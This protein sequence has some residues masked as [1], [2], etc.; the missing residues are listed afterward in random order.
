MFKDQ[1]A[2]LFEVAA[3]VCYKMGGIYTGLTTKA[4]Y[5]QEMWGDRYFLVGPYLPNQNYEGVFRPARDEDIP[6]NSVRQAVRMMR[7]MGASI[8]AG[9]WL[10]ESRPFVLLLDATIT[11]PGYEEYFTK[12]LANY[13]PEPLPA[14]SIIH[15]YLRFGHCLE[16]FFTELSVCSPGDEPRTIIHFHEYMTT[17]AMPV[18]NKLGMRTIFTTHAT[19]IGRHFAPSFKYFHQQFKDVNWK[20]RS[21][22][23][24]E[25]HKF[26]KNVEAMAAAHCH[27]LTSVSE[28]LANE[29][30]VL[31]GRR[32]DIITPNGLN[33][34][35][36][37][38]QADNDPTGARRQIEEAVTKY[39]GQPIGIDGGRTW[40]FFTSGRYEFL[41]K[42]YGTMAQALGKLNNWLKETKSKDTVVAF[43]I[44]DNPYAHGP[45]WFLKLNAIKRKL[46]PKKSRIFFFDVLPEY[47]DSR[48]MRSIRKSKLRNKS[49]DRVKVLY[50]PKF[51][52]RQSP[53]LPMDYLHFVTGCDLGIFPS[54]YEPY[55]FTPVECIGVH[56]PAVLS[57]VTGLA[58]YILNHTK[59]S[60][61]AGVFIIDRINSDGVDNLFHE[62]QKFIQYP[63]DYSSGLKEIAPLFDWSAVIRT[64]KLMYD[65][66]LGSIPAMA[67]P[68]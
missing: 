17:L 64:Y 10:I 41:N 16:L 13:H 33:M 46:F 68:A 50:H 25:Y 19:V 3:E 36:L 43:F 56:V 67:I 57:N 27:V 21:R 4:P 38:K 7:D 62:L 5:V 26:C 59:I 24:S 35:N 55:G 32:P 63:K 1:E 49:S 23:M 11:L 28:V 29:C 20:E 40:Y 51:L 9:H 54:L 37:E 44:T 12:Q 61:D 34:A 52:N 18:L 2:L 48:L 58:D 6:H 60:S 30:S 42:G 31:L 14:D 53:V 39:F 15:Y 66:A 8:H 45:A 65:K 22:S 47:E